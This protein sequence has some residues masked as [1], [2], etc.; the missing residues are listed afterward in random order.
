MCEEDDDQRDFH[1]PEHYWQREDIT[2]RLWLRGNKDRVTCTDE[3]P[4]ALLSRMLL[5]QFCSFG[6]TLERWPSWFQRNAFPSASLKK[7][8]TFLSHINEP[9]TVMPK[10]FDGRKLEST[11]KDGSD[12]SDEDEEKKP[13]RAESYHRYWRRRWAH[14]EV[15]NSVKVTKTVVGA[16]HA[17][18]NYDTC[19]WPK[20]CLVARVS[21]GSAVQQQCSSAA[22]KGWRFVP[23]AILPG[24]RRAPQWVPA[25][26]LPVHW[27][28]E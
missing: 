2:R 9:V 11:T 22:D 26:T 1:I 24:H 23:D 13:W 18:Q 4:N 5:C 16:V 6:R 7:S 20:V 17:G 14:Q 19:A 27:G 21:T 8:P 25:R 12:P 15:M 28:P 3:I 10:E